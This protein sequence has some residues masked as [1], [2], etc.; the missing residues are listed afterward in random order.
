MPPV[1]KWIVDNSSDCYQFPVELRRFYEHGT[2]FIQPFLRLHPWLEALDSEISSVDSLRQNFL[3]DGQNFL[4][5]VDEYLQARKWQEFVLGCCA[6]KSRAQEIPPYPCMLLELLRYISSDTN[7]TTK[8]RYL[9]Q[10][11]D[12]RGLLQI[13]HHDET[14]PSSFIDAL[15]ERASTPP[16]I[17]TR[18]VRSE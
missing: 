3:L 5:I 6:A 17:P 16:A 7:V 1:E 9:P 11:Q 10:S 2:E 15:N 13:S 14:L 18:L 12:I 8:A 4:A